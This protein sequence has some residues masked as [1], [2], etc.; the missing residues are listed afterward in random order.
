[1][2]LVINQS[3][4]AYALPFAERYKLFEDDKDALAFAESIGFGGASFMRM[5]LNKK[6]GVAN[7][8]ACGDVDVM[9]LCLEPE[10]KP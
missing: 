6:P 1:M 7:V 2:Y 8:Y 10:K 9:V 5:E 3:K 4:Q